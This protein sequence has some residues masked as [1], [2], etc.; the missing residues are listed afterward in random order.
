MLSE[1]FTISLKLGD[2]IFKSKGATMLEAISTLPIP[3]KIFLKGI[4]TLKH[5]D[6]V[7]EL[8]LTVPRL[9]RLFY[10]VSQNL[11]AKQYEL[12]IK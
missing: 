7:R 6:S 3:R 9:K 8:A 11:L 2:E 4:L 5:G 10:K 12:L 1:D